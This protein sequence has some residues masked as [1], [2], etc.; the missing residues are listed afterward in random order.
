MGANAPA[1]F[2]LARRHVRYSGDL[3]FASLSM[4]A[5]AP[6]GLGLV[7]RQVSD[8]TFASHLYSNPLL[9]FDMALRLRR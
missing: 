5:H 6:V 1:G 4:G 9:I 2:V 8:T 7:W 3:A